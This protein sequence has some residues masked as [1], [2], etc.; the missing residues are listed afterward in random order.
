MSRTQN[1]EYEDLEEGAGEELLEHDEEDCVPSPARGQVRRGR[2]RPS[3]VREPVP[4]CGVF[5]SLV[6]A[7]ML[8]LII[9]VIAAAITAAAYGFGR[10]NIRG[11]CFS[12]F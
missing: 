7:I 6:M 5:R 3:V 10:W 9:A 4:C 1:E 8:M 11:R 2:G 12:C